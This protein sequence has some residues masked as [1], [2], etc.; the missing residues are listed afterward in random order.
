MVGIYLIVLL[1]HPTLVM[2]QGAAM[3]I[4]VVIFVGAVMHLGTVML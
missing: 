1:L 4:G 3:Q 2:F